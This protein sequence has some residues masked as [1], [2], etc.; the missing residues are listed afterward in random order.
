[1][2]D[3]IVSL[4]KVKETL[5]ELGVETTI[6]SNF[7]LRITREGAVRILCS[8]VEDEVSEQILPERVAAL[9]CKEMGDD[10]DWVGITEYDLLEGGVLD[11]DYKTIEIW[12]PSQEWHAGYEELRSWLTRKQLEAEMFQK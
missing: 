7:D 11:E 10:D 6:G 8:R 4:R 5:S 3:T 9:M 12:L 2:H 1:M